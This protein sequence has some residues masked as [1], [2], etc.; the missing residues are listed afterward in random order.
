MTEILTKVWLLC[1]ILK[2]IKKCYQPSSR[3]GTVV[4]HSMLGAVLHRHN[5]GLFLVPQN[6]TPKPVNVKIYTNLSFFP[7]I[8]VHEQLATGLNRSECAYRETHKMEPKTKEM[9][10]FRWIEIIRLCPIG[11]N[12]V[13]STGQC[14]TLVNSLTEKSVKILNR[15]PVRSGKPM[16]LFD[17]FL[18]YHALGPKFDTPP[19]QIIL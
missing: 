1:E 5:K 18:F 12:A 15:P 17:F 11:Q 7:S 6:K 14:H 4:L 3:V 13:K 8:L 10:S 2:Q 16:T 9:G 19:L